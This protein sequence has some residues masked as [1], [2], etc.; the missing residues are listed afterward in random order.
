MSAP[1]RMSPGLVRRPARTVPV[2]LLGVVFLGVGGV[3]LVLGVERLIGGSTPHWARAVRGVHRL[4]PWSSRFALVLAITLVIIGALCLAAALVPGR[5]GAL[6][7]RPTDGA[8]TSRE[9][10]IPDR[11]LEGW[12]SRWL[13]GEDGVSSA[14]ARVRGRVLLVDVDTPVE[15]SQD[16]ADRLTAGAGRRVDDLGLAR[17]LTVK[18]RFR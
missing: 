15:P 3:A 4:A 12:V 13:L 6:R 9:V 11:E 18:V 17:P 1:R 16:L 10:A 7:L 14:R 8:T 2:A 5:T